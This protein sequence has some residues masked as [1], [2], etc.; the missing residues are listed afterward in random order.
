MKKTLLILSIFSALTACMVGPKYR[1]T[2]MKL[3]AAYLRSDASI[4]GKDSV[5]ALKWFDL[6]KDPVLGGLVD[7]ALRRNYDLKS[8][9]ARISQAEAAY[10]IARAGLLPSLSYSA[11]ATETSGKSFG[12]NSFSFGAGLSWELDIWGKIRHAKRA[13][14]DDLLAAEETRKAVQ[15]TLVAAVSNAYFQLRDFDNRLAISI[16]TFKSR[17]TGYTL[18]QERFAKGYISEWDLLQAKQLMEDARASIAVYERAV[19]VTEH[20]LCTLTAMPSG[21][22][23]RGIENA[24]QPVPPVIP[25]GMPSSLLE[26]RPDIKR[27]EYVYMRETE[28]IGIAVAQRYPTLSLTGALGFA[29]SDLTNLLSSDALAGSVSQGILGPIFA[30]GANKRRVE[31]QRNSAEIA[32]NDY[33]NLQLNALREVENA[34]VTIS[35]SSRELQARQDQADAARKVVTLSQARYDNGFTS[36]LELLDAQR[37]LFETDLLVSAVRQQQ[38]NA[39]VE[40]YRAL[41]GGW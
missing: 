20:Y 35:T 41:G 6:F 30:F 18:Q 8:A 28:R 33:C 31:V 13:A 25:S 29:S 16:V 7:S 22:V 3:P 17:E 2:D 12:P 40:L 15:S 21:S 9:I 24:A 23:A 19:A 32:A 36:Y 38:L 10:G 4:S 26:Q 5:G 37:T 34:L 27:A 39:Y 1:R 11:T 14:L